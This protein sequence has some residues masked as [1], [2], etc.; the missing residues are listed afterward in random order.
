V[1]GQTSLGQTF[2]RFPMHESCVAFELC[3][4]LIKQVMASRA[5][6]PPPGPSNTFC[7]DHQSFGKGVRGHDFALVAVHAQSHHS[8]GTLV[9]STMG[10]L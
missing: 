4:V 3:N 6:S 9:A 5:S 1:G 2:R 7:V 10:T 8:E